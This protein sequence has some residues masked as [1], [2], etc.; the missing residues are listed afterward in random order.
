MGNIDFAQLKRD[1]ADTLAGIDASK[2]TKQS[3][4]LL[5]A[6]LAILDHDNATMPVTALASRS[7]PPDHTPEYYAEDELTAAQEYH[8]MGLDWIARDELKH[9]KYWI[10]QMPRNKREYM[11]RYDELAKLVGKA[12]VS[13]GVLDDFSVALSRYSDSRSAAD[14]EAMRATLKQQLSE[15]ERELVEMRLEVHDTEAVKMFGEFK[16]SMR[17]KL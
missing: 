2:L 4:L 3:Y 16:E 15:I 8:S 6:S 5:G 9:A 17:L 7:E 12:P 10:D 11:A 1:A 14:R 13:S